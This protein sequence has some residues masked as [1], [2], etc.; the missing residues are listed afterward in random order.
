MSSGFLG[1]LGMAT[2]YYSVGLLIPAAFAH[3]F[4]AKGVAPRMRRRVA[5][6]ATVLRLLPRRASSS[7]R[8]TT[9][10][11]RTSSCSRC[12]RT[13]KRAGQLVG[14]GRSARS[15]SRRRSRIG[16]VDRDG[17][18]SIVDACAR[19][20]R[21]P[22]HARW[23]RARVLRPGG[24][25]ALVLAL[26]RSTRLDVFMLVAVLGPGPVHRDRQPAVL[27]AAAPGRA[28]PAARGLDRGRRG[29]PARLRRDGFSRGSLRR[30]SSCALLLAASS[31]VPAGGPSVARML[32][33]RVARAGPRPH[34]ASRRSA[35]SRGTFPRA[36]SSSTTTRCCRSRR[37][38]RARDWAIDRLKRK[39]ADRRSGRTCG[40]GSTGRPRRPTVDRPS[41][42]LL[43]DRG[44][45]GDARTST[46]SSSTGRPTTRPGRE[47][48][49]RD[50]RTCP[51][52]RATPT[53]PKA[54]ARLLASKPAVATRPRGDVARDGVAARRPARSSGWS[55]PRRP[56]TTTSRTPRRRARK[57]SGSRGVLRRPEGALRLPAVVGQ[58]RRA[59]RA[60]RY[61][62]TTC[63]SGLLKILR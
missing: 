42:D 58:L 47:T 8:R 18:F 43:V 34:A 55:A 1:G 6:L 57:L 38:R 59:R 48:S 45:L 22:V 40:A 62:C 32:A 63:A 39:R 33:D 35:G 36:P 16:F 46:R 5:L 13:L 60:R 29:V 14:L 44:A 30:A 2:K 50:P 31:A 56:T 41:Y 25:A 15:A 3:L 17:K 9:S 53:C 23:H 10:C 26:V 37:T 24:R 27:G 61:A 52:S 12:C 4:P 7:A 51:R 11:G 19:A 49:L 54:R 21:E 28:L 20:G